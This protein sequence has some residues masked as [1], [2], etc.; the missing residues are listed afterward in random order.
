MEDTSHNFYSKLQ[1]TRNYLLVKDDVGKSKPPI[2]DLP[3]G[4]FTYG[5]KTAEN[6][7]G[8]GAVIS[9]WQF[10]QQ[11]KMLK[12][13]KD[14]TKLNAMGV[15]A[16]AVTAPKQRSFRTQADARIKTATNFKKGKRIPDIMFGD[17]SRPSTPIKAVI[18]NYYGAVASEIKNERYSSKLEEKRLPQSRNTRASRMMSDA[19]K[20]SMEEPQP[21]QFKMKKFQ[22]TAPRTDTNLR[23]TT[24]A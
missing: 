1:G 10:H 11:T 5:K 7:E 16:G 18:G 4:E 6:E 12:P 3:N 17:A 20:Q 13:E 22:K 21:S 9:T 14:F 15:A 19:I 23:P 2:R 8:A 24:K